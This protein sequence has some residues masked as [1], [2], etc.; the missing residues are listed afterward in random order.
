MPVQKNRN[1]QRDQE[2]ESNARIYFF[3]EKGDSAK[4]NNPTIDFASAAVA[5][6]SATDSLFV[7]YWFF[8]F[9]APHAHGVSLNE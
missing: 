8:F 2:P 1:T 5:A 3:E 4:T 9:I 7:L 6:A